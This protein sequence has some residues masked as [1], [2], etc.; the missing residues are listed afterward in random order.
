NEWTSTH[1]DFGNTRTLH[2][3]IPKR[4]P[5]ESLFDKDKTYAYPNPA[6]GGNV[7]LRIAVESA[8]NVEIMIYD[9]AGYFVERFESNLIQGTIHEINWNVNDL[10]SGVYFANVKATKGSKSDSKILKIGIIK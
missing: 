8:E 1:H 10:E 9:F 5:D 2:L 4:S 7:K 6:Y 3:N